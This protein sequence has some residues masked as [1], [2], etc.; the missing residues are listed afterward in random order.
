MARHDLGRERDPVIAVHFPE[1]VAH[2][3]GG[4]RCQLDLVAD[5][6]RLIPADEDVHFAVEGG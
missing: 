6:I 2:L 3:A 1:H 4:G 5:G